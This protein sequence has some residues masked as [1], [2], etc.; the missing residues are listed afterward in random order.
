MTTEGSTALHVAK[1]RLARN[2]A[3][4]ELAPR[5]VQER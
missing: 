5:V 4:T 1:W 2:L 3:Y